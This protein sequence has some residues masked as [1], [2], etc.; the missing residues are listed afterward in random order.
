MMRLHVLLDGIDIYSKTI[1]LF[2]IANIVQTI[3]PNTPIMGS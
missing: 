1:I 3:E 2:A